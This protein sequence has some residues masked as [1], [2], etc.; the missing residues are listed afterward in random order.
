MSDSLFSPL[1]LCLKI[2]SHCSPGWPGTHYIAEA[3]LKFMELLAVLLTLLSVG[4]IG[5]SHHACFRLFL[6]AIYLWGGSLFRDS[7]ALKTAYV[8]ALAF[9]PY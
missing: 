6:L 4:I 9:C 8:L 2:T 5:M 3:R 7:E 1:V